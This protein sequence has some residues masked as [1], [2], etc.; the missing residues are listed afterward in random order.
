MIKVFKMFL[1][2]ILLFFSTITSY[3][4]LTI[5]EDEPR[6]WCKKGDP[7]QKL[8]VFPFGYD[9]MGY[10][11]PYKVG[12]QNYCSFYDAQTSLKVVAN[13]LLVEC[14]PCK[15]TDVYLLIG[16]AN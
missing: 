1:I 11:E 16:I 13:G 15:G 10:F 14:S 6:F 9:G 12:E 7:E 5:R 2:E 8:A 4:S 3:H